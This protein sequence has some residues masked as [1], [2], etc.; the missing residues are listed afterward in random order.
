M[1][2]RRSLTI[3]RLEGS[4]AKSASCKRPPV[5]DEVSSGIRN[6]CRKRLISSLFIIDR[7]MR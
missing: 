4:P 7:S 3:I 1:N 2:M 6:E 5:A